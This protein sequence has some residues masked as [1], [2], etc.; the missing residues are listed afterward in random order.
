[1]NLGAALV[2]GVL[3]ARIEQALPPTKAILTGLE[4][5]VGL[6]KKWRPGL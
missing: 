1:V 5:Q 2:I 6:F 3:V 4:E